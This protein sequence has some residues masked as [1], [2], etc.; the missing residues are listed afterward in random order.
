VVLRTSGAI[1]RVALMRF[2]GSH[3][4]RTTASVL[5]NRIRPLAKRAIMTVSGIGLS[6]P[7][8]SGSH[9]LAGKRAPDLAL[10]SGRLYE[11][12]RDGRFVLVTPH[13]AR[14]RAEDPRFAQE[15]SAG[16]GRYTLLIRPDGYIAWAGEGLDPKG[17][18]A[19]LTEWTGRAA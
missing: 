15:E 16:T 6:Y 7:S 19:A 4:L 12:L 11:A 9:R 2:P 10:A 3:T 5:V 14:S 1:I 17:L 8:P 18:G 13:G